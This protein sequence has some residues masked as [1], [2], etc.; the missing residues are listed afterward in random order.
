MKYSTL[1]R[2]VWMLLLII[3]MEVTAPYVQKVEK[4]ERGTEEIAQ[5][6][7]ESGKP[8]CSRRL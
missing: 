3:K 7:E 8:G 1:Y 6:L 4:D 2:N 5:N